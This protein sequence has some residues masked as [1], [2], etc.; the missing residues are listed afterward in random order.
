VLI[1]HRTYHVLPGRVPAQLELYSKLGYPVQLR[2]MG[3]PLCYMVSESGD[4]NRLVHCWIYDNAG[5]R[6]AKRTR[7]AQDPEWKHFVAENAKA[8]N[9]SQQVTM[10]MTP[11]MFSPKLT[12]P[13]PLK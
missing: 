3:E 13:A 12:V 10:L 11:T 1:D 9:I 2:H 5:D 4:L 6:E 7:M 8:G